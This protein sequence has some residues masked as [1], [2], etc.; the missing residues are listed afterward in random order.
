LYQTCFP[1]YSEQRSLLV[2]SVHEVNWASTKNTNND[3]VNSIRLDKTTTNTP[4]IVYKTVDPPKRRNSIKH[5]STSDYDNMQRF[6]KHN[7]QN[8][9]NKAAPIMVSL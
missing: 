8:D 1:I 6:V 3:T 2:T 5:L 4:T 7:A 9:G